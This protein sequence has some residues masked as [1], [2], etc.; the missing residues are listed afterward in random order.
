M[1]TA[2]LSTSRLAVETASAVAREMESD[3]VRDLP[4]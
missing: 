1:S 3:L 2:V 4:D